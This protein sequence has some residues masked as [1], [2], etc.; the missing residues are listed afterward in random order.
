MELCWDSYKPIVDTEKCLYSKGCRRCIKVCSG[1]GLDLDAFSEKLFP[2]LSVDDGLGR[3]VALHTGYSQEHRLRFHGA[4]GGVVTGFLSYLLD[5]GIIGAAV[6]TGFSKNNPTQAEAILAQSSE[7]L[8]KA[9]SSKYC[10]VSM[11]GI[12][13]QV[14]ASPEKVIV[15]GLPCHIHGFRK[16]ATVDKKFSDKILGYFGLYCSSTRTSLLPEYLLWKYG[17]NKK[18]VR[19]FAFRGNGYPGF[20]TVLM[21]SGDE[22]QVPY[23]EYYRNIRACFNQRRCLLCYDHAAELADVAFGDIHIPEFLN[24]HVGVNSIIVRNPYFE[25]LLQEADREGTIAI[26]DVER[27]RVYRSQKNM[28]RMKKV[29]I[30]TV[31]FLRK[32]FFQ[33]VPD[34]NIRLQGRRITFRR[35]ASILVNGLQSEVGR[36]RWAWRWVD[37]IAKLCAGLGG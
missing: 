35:I 18:D 28:I 5:K 8:Y 33:Q 20:L 11:H 16:L 24:D 4:S 2:G 7:E 31:Y 3:Y 6:V 26:D 10:P 23:H 30:H 29:R 27:E 37:K 21:K 9:K 19:S 14:V 25:G 34:W 17:V 12:Y 15:V 13:D 32:M 1:E 22:L 36:R